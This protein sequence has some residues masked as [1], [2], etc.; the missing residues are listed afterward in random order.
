MADSSLSASELR[1][2]YHRGGTANDDELNASQ[3]R[4][5]HGIMSNKKNFS[6]SSNSNGVPIVA[7]VG[8]ILAAIG[9]AYFLYL[10]SK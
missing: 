4:A 7:I 1:Q 8:I 6:T 5:R 10:S 3:L 9:V 2:R